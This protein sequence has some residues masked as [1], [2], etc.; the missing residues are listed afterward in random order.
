M[1]FTKELFT[2]INNNNINSNKIP[3]LRYTLKRQRRFFDKRF[4]NISKQLEENNHEINFFANTRNSLRPEIFPKP[5]LE[6]EMQELEMA[7]LNY[8]LK[9]NSDL[10]SALKLN[11]GKTLIKETAKFFGNLNDIGKD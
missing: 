11:I 2:S 6:L 9:F 8:L 1:Q 5:K 7:Y 3:E 10:H 4:I